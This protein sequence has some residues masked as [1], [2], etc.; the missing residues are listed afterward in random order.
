MGVDNE[1]HAQLLAF[2]LQVNEK[3]ES[4]RWFN[5]CYDSLGYPKI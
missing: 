1:G 3:I 2:G 4:F 5:E